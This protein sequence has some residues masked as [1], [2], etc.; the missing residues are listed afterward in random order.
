MHTASAGSPHLPPLSEPSSPETLELKQQFLLRVGEVV[1]A[2]GTPSHRMEALLRR[3]AESLELE[4]HFLVTPTSLIVSLGR[5]RNEQTRLLRAEP[6]QVDLGRLVEIDELLEDVED[7]HCDLPTG[8]ARLEELAASGRRH[9]PMLTALAFGVSGAGAAVFLG[10][11]VWEVIASFA[12]G[13]VVFV[14]GAVLGRSPERVHLTD[15]MM[16]FLAAGSALAWDTYVRPVDYTIVTLAAL[17]ILIPGLSFTVAMLE[18]ATR[19]LSSGVARLAGAAVTMLLIVLGVALA[20]KVGGAQAPVMG[21]WLLPDAWRWGIMAMA[22]IGFAVLFQARVREWWVIY[23]AGAMG[24]VGAHF[25][26]QLLGPDLGPFLGA[27]AVGLVGNA[28]A[29]LFDRPSSV[30]QMPGILLIVPGTVGYKSL[31]A[32]LS[33]ERLE[34]ALQGTGLAVRMVM[35]G[36]ALVG[37]LLTATAILSPR[38]SL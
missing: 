19:H 20:W 27:L 8:L 11:Q 12:I 26:G 5:G 28:Y 18:L 32:F 9:G 37:G 2:Y 30:A 10:G 13:I 16:A 1:H 15:G 7:R 17:I 6:S 3:M 31:T 25:G 36:A 14:A 24:F 29:R 22:P 33:D 35:V 34:S 21:T 38:R 4:A 23:L